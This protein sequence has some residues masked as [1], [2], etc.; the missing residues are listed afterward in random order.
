MTSLL[1]RARH[2]SFLLGYFILVIELLLVIPPPPSIVAIQHIEELAGIL[3]WKA[4]E[5]SPSF[6]TGGTSLGLIDII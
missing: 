5:D 3:L 4:L 6:L 2:T 1:D